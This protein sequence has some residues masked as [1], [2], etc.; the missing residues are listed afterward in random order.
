MHQEAEGWDWVHADIDPEEPGWYDV[1][2]F[3]ELRSPY[4][5]ECKS[6]YW[7][8]NGWFYDEDCCVHATMSADNGDRWKE[9]RKLLM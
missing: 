2:R 4:K 8:G 9:N 1:L 3:N 7:C 5:V 6:L